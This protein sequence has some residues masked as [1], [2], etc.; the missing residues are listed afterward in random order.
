MDGGPNLGIWKSKSPYFF[1][2]PHFISLKSPYSPYLLHIISMFSPYSCCIFIRYIFS[3]FLMRR[4]I[5]IWRTWV[6]NS[7]DDTD[8]WG[9][10]IKFK[11][12]TNPMLYS[13]KSTFLTFSS[14]NSYRFPTRGTWSICEE[15]WVLVITIIFRLWGMA[16]LS[17]LWDSHK[18]LRGI[19]V[20]EC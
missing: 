5:K 12:V 3:I 19:F 17:I 20:R 11:F 8:I 7:I 18:I 4:S 9:M 13:T 2:I 6:Q 14:Q 16:K 10:G 1:H 15:F